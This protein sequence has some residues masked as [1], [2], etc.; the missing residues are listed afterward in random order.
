MATKVWGKLTNGLVVLEHTFTGPASY[1]SGGSQ[2]V[3]IQCN[4]VVAVLDIGVH[5]SS[6]GYLARPAGISRNML[7]YRVYATGT[8][9]LSSGTVLTP[10]TF[11]AVVL[12][13]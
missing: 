10:Y 4:K 7:F 8:V 9:E 11:K 2:Y 6:V 5:D 13:L 3:Q 12:G 1:Q